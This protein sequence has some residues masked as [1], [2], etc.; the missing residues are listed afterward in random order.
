[1]KTRV[2]HVRA[3]LTLLRP[4]RILRGA[5]TEKSLPRRGLVAAALLVLT[6]VAY[7]GVRHC[8]FLRYDDDLYVS[9]NPHLAEGMTPRAI[10]WAFT[11]DLVHDSPNADYW[12]PLTVLSRLVD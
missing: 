3:A 1:M 4:S 12:S 5:V 10:R 9:A 7:E 6:V 2:S 11:A 8:G